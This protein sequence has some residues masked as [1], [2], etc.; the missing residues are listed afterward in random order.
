MR[1]I[2][3]EEKNDTP[4]WMFSFHFAFETYCPF[5]QITRSVAQYGFKD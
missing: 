4:P 1:K 5:F 3:V 2:A